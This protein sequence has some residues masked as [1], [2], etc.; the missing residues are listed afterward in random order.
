VESQSFMEM[1][2]LVGPV[3]LI[4]LIMLVAGLVDLVPRQRTH[5]PKWVWYLVVI[6]GPVVYFLFGRED[7]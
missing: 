2:P 1:L 3:L 6:L 7:E 5:G 4:W